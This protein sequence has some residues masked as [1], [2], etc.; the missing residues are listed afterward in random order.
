MSAALAT[1][2]LDAVH[3]RDDRE[4]STDRPAES[5]GSP[6]GQNVS[7]PLARVHCESDRC[8]S[9]AVTSL[10]ATMLRIAPRASALVTRRSRSTDDDADLSFVLDLR[11]LRRQHDGLAVAR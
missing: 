4:A 3:A 10:A 2:A 7:N 8:K 9:R 5:P 11:R 6:I 1:L